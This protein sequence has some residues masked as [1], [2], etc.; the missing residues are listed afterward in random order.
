MAAKIIMSRA[1]FL[2]RERGGLTKGFVVE[3]KKYVF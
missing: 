1:I 3:V 2:N